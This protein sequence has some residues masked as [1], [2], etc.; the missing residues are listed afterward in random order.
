MCAASARELQLHTSAVV[1]PIKV[2]LRI[3]EEGGGKVLEL[4]WP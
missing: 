1:I 2:T 4:F 3:T